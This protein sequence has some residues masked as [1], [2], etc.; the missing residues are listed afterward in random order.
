MHGRHSECRHTTPN[1]LTL[2]T[3]WFLKNS[4]RTC[5]EENYQPVRGR[6]EGT[7][8]AWVT[9][10]LVQNGPG[11]FYFG[12]SVFQH[13]FDG[14]ALVRKFHIDQG[15]VTYQCQFVK[16]QSYKVTVTQ[17]NIEIMCS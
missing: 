8:P 4:S 10:S 17:L 6:R 5:L 13:L 15:E 16:T 11:K 7:I 14:S 3:N 1:P 2:L 9:G 12:S